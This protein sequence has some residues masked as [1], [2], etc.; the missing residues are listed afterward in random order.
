MDTKGK[1]FTVLFIGIFVGVVFG[2]ET[3]NISNSKT[4]PQLD[5]VDK[6]DLVVINDRYY[7][8]QAYKL[9]QDSKTSIHLAMFE[10]KYYPRFPISPSNKLVKEI[11]QAH[12]R[13]VE[14]KIVMDQ[15]VKDNSAFDLIAENNISIK[16]D[17]EN[18]TLHAKLIIVDG[19][20]VMVGSTNPT[21]YGLEKNRETNVYIRNEEIAQQYEQWFQELWDEV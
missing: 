18:Q 15:Y 5:Q 12:Q 20:K 19:E 21:Y 6:A 4:C 8:P 2:V 14:V 13:G 17:S 3:V 7:F 1:L 10:L 9:I 11:I 16:Y